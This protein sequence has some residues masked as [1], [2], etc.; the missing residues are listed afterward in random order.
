MSTAHLFYKSTAVSPFLSI[1]QSRLAIQSAPSSA[2]RPFCF[3]GVTFRIDNRN[4]RRPPCAAVA[5]LDVV[6]REVETTARRLDGRFWRLD[7][8]CPGGIGT[9]MLPAEF[10]RDDGVIMTAAEMGA[11]RVKLRRDQPGAVGLPDVTLNGGAVRPGPEWIWRR[12]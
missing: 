8:L 1:S 2:F 10:R 7:A 4:R 5:V 12:E 9:P 3:G 6:E 11:I